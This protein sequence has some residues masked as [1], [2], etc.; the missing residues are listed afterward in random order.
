MSFEMNRNKHRYNDSE[1]IVCCSGGIEYRKEK[2]KRKK[3]VHIFCDY[4]KHVSHAAD[5]LK[6]ER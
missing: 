3:K 4:T 6:I 1:W 2:R 5:P